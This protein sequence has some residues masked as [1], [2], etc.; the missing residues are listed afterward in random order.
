MRF[1]AISFHGKVL[2]GL[3]TF[4]TRGF[5]R[6]SSNEGC[7]NCRPSLKRVEDP[8]RSPRPIQIPSAPEDYVRRRRSVSV[9]TVR[10][11]L[12]SIR[13]ATSACSQTSSDRNL[14]FLRTYHSFTPEPFSM[15]E[16]PVHWPRSADPHEG[17]LAP[18]AGECPPLQPLH[19]SLIARREYHRA[20]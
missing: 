16:L 14:A 10:S 2:S 18:L 11:K 6:G 3:C 15:I 20:S 12:A 7:R 4:G 5:F 19:A 1:A 8:F 9:Q 13:P 17:S